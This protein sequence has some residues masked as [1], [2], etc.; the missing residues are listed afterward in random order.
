MK[1]LSKRQITILI[2][3]AIVM[4]FGI[5][6]FFIS[7]SSKKS[8]IDISQKSIEMPDFM[9]QFNDTSKRDSAS[10]LYIYTA[11]RAEAWWL[12]NPFFSQRSY[13]EFVTSD[14]YSKISKDATKGTKA[15]FIYSGYLTLGRVKMAII[16]GIEYKNGEPLEERGYLLKNIYPSKVVIE[17]NVDKIRFDVPFQE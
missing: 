17:N 6:Y 5:Y 7:P 4:L 9:T 11:S 16:N 14:E 15:M 8:Q 13:V 3:M 2:V 10:N 1:K 12:R